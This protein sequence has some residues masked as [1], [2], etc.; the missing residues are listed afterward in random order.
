MVED[1][2][3]ELGVEQSFDVDEPLHEIVLVLE[4]I[5]KID[6][7]T[8]EKGFENDVHQL[9][10]L[11]V[12]VGET[13]L[14]KGLQLRKVVWNKIFSFLPLI[15]V[16]RIFVDPGDFPKE[17]NWGENTT[18]N[19]IKE[20][21]I[22][23]LP[24]VLDQDDHVNDCF[25]QIDGLVI[26][27]DFVVQV[28]DV[29][30]DYFLLILRDEERVVLRR[31]VPVGQNVVFYGRQN[32]CQDLGLLIRDQHEQFL[33]KSG[34]LAVLDEEDFGLLDCAGVETAFEDIEQVVHG[35]LS[36]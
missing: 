16:T 10:G 29:L 19:V 9:G 18:A 25:V 23:S 20:L 12:E 22:D 27:A 32:H 7:D 24:R 13:L 34:F 3:L 14:D 36:I 15:L 6:V 4:V 21:L 30:H 28:Q 11:I 17:V 2:V 35:R 1:V 31:R 26:M 33:E 5:W 8:G